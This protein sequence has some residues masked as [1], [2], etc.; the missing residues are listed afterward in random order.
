MKELADL[1]LDLHHSTGPDRQLDIHIGLHVGYKRKVSMKLEE[2]KKRRVVTWFYPADTEIRRIPYFT[3]SIDDAAD[4]VQT[5]LPGA[6]AGFTW[7]PPYYSARVDGGPIFNGASP[8][9]ALCIAALSAKYQI[10]PKS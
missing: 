1:I 6:A 2:G 8:A 4:L 3:R 10:R 9:I 5:V 7:D